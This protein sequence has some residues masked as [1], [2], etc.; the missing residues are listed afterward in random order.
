ML[1]ATFSRAPLAA[2]ERALTR[3]GMLL[4]A[5]RLMDVRLTSNQQVKEEAENFIRLAD[6][7]Q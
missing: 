3:L 2:T 7:A 5:T 1:D 4:A 6:A